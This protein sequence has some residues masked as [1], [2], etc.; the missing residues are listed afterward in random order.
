MGALPTEWGEA[1]RPLLRSP[2][3]LAA[4]ARL[5]SRAGEVIVWLRCPPCCVGGR[6]LACQGKMQRS[7]AGGVAEMQCLTAPARG[8]RGGTAF[9]SDAEP[10]G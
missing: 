10:N 2:P 4:Y 8:R 1:E 6:G 7:G 9:V 3:E 5:G